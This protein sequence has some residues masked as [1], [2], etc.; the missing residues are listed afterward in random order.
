MTKE[1][2]TCPL[3]VVRAPDGHGYTLEAAIP[4]SALGFKP[5]PGQ[6]I[7]LDLAVDDSDDG[8]RRTR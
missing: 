2:L 1:N 5:Q 7:R 6:Q 8:L 3:A 4:W